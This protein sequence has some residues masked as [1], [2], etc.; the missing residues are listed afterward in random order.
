MELTSTVSFCLLTQ[1]SVE[2]P[3]CNRLST[4]EDGLKRVIIQQTDSFASPLRVFGSHR[5]RLA[6]LRIFNQFLQTKMVWLC[7]QSLL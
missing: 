4:H 1:A 6:S 5:T 3:E 7:T 2:Y